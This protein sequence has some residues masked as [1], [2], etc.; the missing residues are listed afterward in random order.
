MIVARQG[1]A[2]AMLGVAIGLAGAVAL[3]RYLGALLF[4][5]APADPVVFALSGLLMLLLAAAA[6][7]I[8]ARRAAAVDPAL[9]L[10]GE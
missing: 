1:V 9:A 7:W 2:V 10:K 5:V 8:P 4:A 3:A 6:S